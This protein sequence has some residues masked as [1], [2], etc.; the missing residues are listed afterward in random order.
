MDYWVESMQDDAYLIAADGWVA[1]PRRIIEQMKKGK[2]DNAQIVEKDKGWACDLIPKPYIVARYFAAEERAIDKT[3]AELEAT[4]TAIAELEETHSGEDMV[5]AN[6]DKINAAQ[7]KERIREIGDD[8][9]A[10]EELA[11]LK[12]W[13]ALSE[14]QTSVKKKQR[15]QEVALDKQAYE[16]YPQLSVAEI[17]AL[18]VEDKWLAAL[19]SAI[20]GELERVSQNLTNRARELASRYESPLPKLEAEVA[21]LSAKVETHLCQMG[22]VWN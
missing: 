22:V 7:M 1:Q 19:H 17:K 15:A 8:K 12:Q 21:A 5:F 10:A 3:A 18:V 14:K 20:A 16:K 2:G 9:D 11:V 13:L 6:F 4:D